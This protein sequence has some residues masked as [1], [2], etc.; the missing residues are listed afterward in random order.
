MEAGIITVKLHD[1]SEYRVYFAN[2][3]QKQRVFIKCR[4]NAKIIKSYEVTVNG[5]NTVNHFEI[6][7]DNNF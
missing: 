7:L 4:Q 2:R 1:D 6:I 5:V 3:S